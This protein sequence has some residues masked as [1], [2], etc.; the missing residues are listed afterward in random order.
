MMYAILELDTDMDMQL[1][2]PGVLENFVDAHIVIQGETK[3]ELL[4]KAIKILDSII[5]TPFGDE[6]KVEEYRSAL[7]KVRTALWFGFSN[8]SYGG[9]RTVKFIANDVIGA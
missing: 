8:Y 1:S 7:S 5:I 6:D 2:I 4:D 9:N 3:V